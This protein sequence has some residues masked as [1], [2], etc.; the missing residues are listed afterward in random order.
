MTKKRNRV[1]HGDVLSVVTENGYGFLQYVGRATFGDVVLVASTLKPTATD[2]TAQLFL[3]GYFIMYPAKQAVVEG[4]VQIVGNFQPPEIP[5]IWRRPGRISNS[6]RVETWLIGPEIAPEIVSSLSDQ[7][8]RE[9]IEML[10]SHDALVKQLE[11]GWR[12]EHSKETLS[13]DG[14]SKRIETA[15]ITSATKK[16]V[17]HFV[18]FDRSDAAELF[19]KRCIAEGYLTKIERGAEE[20]SHLVLVSH[21]VK[22][23]DLQQALNDAEG[24]IESILESVNGK[25]DGHEVAV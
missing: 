14:R 6:G 11:N 23:V 1:R 20:M 2:W 3:G 16:L 10:L 19:A 15:N 24:F 9:P 4:L 17:K 5:T 22:D 13:I 21:E 18:Y 25:Y 8:A 12:P 7:Q